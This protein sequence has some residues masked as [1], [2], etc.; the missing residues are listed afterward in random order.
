MSRNHQNAHKARQRS[1]ANKAQEELSWLDN[2]GS[3][4][5]TSFR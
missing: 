5:L 2:D 4:M 3:Q 1:E